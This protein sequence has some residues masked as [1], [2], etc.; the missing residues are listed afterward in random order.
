MN[1]LVPALP[2]GR[3]VALRIGV[4]VTLLVCGIIPR[5]VS[6]QTVTTGK[7]YINL[8]RPNGGT[9]LPGDTIE[10]RATIAVTGGSN[11][12]NN[13]INHIRYTDTINLSKLSYIPGTLRMISN[14]GHIQ[15]QYSDAA[16]TDSAS[17][18]T[19]S[20]QLRFNI[21]S[22]AGACDAA[23]DGTGTASSGSLWGALTPTFYWTTCIRVYVYRAKIKDTASVVD[24][25]SVVTLSAGNFRYRVGN[26]FSD[27][28]SSFANYLIRIAPDYGL[29]S[30]SLGTNALVSESN[31]TFDKGHNKNR[32][33]NS[34]LVPNPYTR[35]MFGNQSPD[36]NYYGI[37]NNTS[38][39]WT[40]NPNII[41]PSPI[42]VFDV[43]DI[44]GDHTGAADPAAG[45]GP[46]DTTVAGS[47]NGYALIINASYETNQAFRQT[48]TNLCEDTYYE[49]SAWFRNICRRC[50][51]DSSGVGAKFSGYTPGP[52]NDSSGVRPN[53][54]FTIDGE[55]YYTSGNI[56]Y[57]GTWVKKGFIYRTRPG[58]HTMTVTIRNNAPGGGGNDWAIDDITIATCTPDMRY[59]PS[60]TPNVCENGT[61]N[62]YDT[63]RSYFDN[64][65]YYKWQRSTDGGT[66]WTDVSGPDGPV[67]PAWNGTAWEYVGGYTVPPTLTTAANWG[68]MYR[69]VVGTTAGNLSDINCQTTDPGSIVTLRVIN[70]EPMLNTLLTG[71]SG[72]LAGLNALLRWT[73]TLEQGLLHFDIERS[74]NGTTFRK[75]GSVEGHNDPAATTNYYTFSDPEPLRTR[76]YYRL[77]M[78]SADNH[79][80]YST[81]V[82]LNPNG[83]SFDILST[84]NPFGNQLHFSLTAPR[85]G[86]IVVSLSNS[87]GQ[88]ALQ[89]TIDVKTGFN[90]LTIPDTQSLPGGVYVLQV[91]MEGHTVRRKVV[92][93]Y[94]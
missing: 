93:R 35:S 33:S 77:R 4:A 76:A 81:V 40:T 6:A 85:D 12:N 90:Q 23:A 56:P 65:V 18:D 9:F 22:G 10:V 92:K 43:W 25:D 27:Q 2:P 67:T 51:C 31:G 20:G 3:S 45:N 28:S 58:Q 60:L 11:S 8:T 7:S 41:M 50:S 24:L 29:C 64:Y 19:G 83:P 86:N 75:A 73:T 13:R 47:K 82:E 70:C 49:F 68:D 57:T 61:L 21:G 55:E 54:S 89:K 62:L 53:L 63:V 87:M 15:V 48:I 84:V 37:A 78:I 66:T 59:S 46:A 30:N 39:T 88:A 42:R 5:I 36:D 38:A 69:M 1:H 44:I 17:I 26:S 32:P 91:N 16:D 34:T 72:Q 52:G 80:T 71:F 94:N 14:E 74:I 79:V